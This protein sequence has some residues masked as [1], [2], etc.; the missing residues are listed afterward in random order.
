MSMVSKRVI[1]AALAA[2]V[3]LGS[4]VAG[5]PALAQDP[6]W[7]GRPGWHPHEHYAD[8]WVVLPGRGRYEVP[9]FRRRYYGNVVV[10]RPFG[11]VYPGYG[12]F[13]TDSAAALYLGLT[14]ITVAALNDL[15]EQQQRALENAQVMATTAPVGTPIAWNSG[16]AAGTVVAVRDGRAADGAYCREFQQTVT[17]GGQPQQ[18]YGTAC[19]GQDGA[20]RVVNP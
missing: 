10:L 14:A 3:A 6:H 4:A 1:T 15:N 5:R 16:P 11:P 18:A 19:Q 13:Y 20:W 17:I 9:E 2:A 8:R 7:W 12:F